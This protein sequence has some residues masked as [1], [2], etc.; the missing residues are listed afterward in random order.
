VQ[1]RQDLRLYQQIGRRDASAFQPP[2]AVLPQASDAG[3]P[4]GANL[5]VVVTVSYSPAPPASTSVEP[6]ADASTVPTPVFAG[7]QVGVEW[8]AAVPPLAEEVPTSPDAPPG[9][10]QP[11][12]AEVCLA[13]PPNPPGTL[14]AGGRDPA[15]EP[16]RPRALPD[17]SAEAVHTITERL[18]LDVRTA[19]ELVAI[20]WQ[21]GR[22]PGY[23]AELI[24][25]IHSQPNIVVPGKAFQRLVETN[26]DRRR[27]GSRT[28]AHLAT[29]TEQD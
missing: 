23:L 24:D 7:A 16:A 11:Q 5:G 3:A 1:I 6:V 28:R 15:P 12:E 13:R 18:P 25:Y 9:I 10:E 21:N 2:P 8:D 26:Q 17:W 29:S 14:P 27:R 19:E 20:A 22:G 4:G